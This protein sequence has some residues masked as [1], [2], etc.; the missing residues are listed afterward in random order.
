MNDNEH[1]RHP[2]LLHRAKIK[3]TTPGSSR[4]FI[5]EMH[6]FSEGGLFLLWPGQFGLTKGSI[7]QIQTTE[8]D[9]APIQTAQVIRIEP[10]TGMALKFIESGSDAD[11]Q[12][13]SDLA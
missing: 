2:R 4:Q 1:R 8:F 9:N 6:D 7:V 12:Q 11:I 5:A 13:T 10:N 3:V